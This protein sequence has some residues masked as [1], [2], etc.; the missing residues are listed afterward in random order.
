MVRKVHPP[1]EMPH[2]DWGAGSSGGT[3]VEYYMLLSFSIFANSES[4]T[5]AAILR[6]LSALEQRHSDRVLVHYPMPTKEDDYRRNLLAKIQ[7][8][9]S[10]RLQK[11]LAFVLICGKPFE[12]FHGDVHSFAIVNFDDYFGEEGNLNEIQL[13]KD[14]AELSELIRTKASVVSYVQEASAKKSSW[15]DALELKP[16]VWGIRFDLRK[17]A[18]L[19]KKT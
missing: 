9:F 18:K 2:G 1:L 14:L 17:Y 11:S 10:E 3:P 15:V 12:R 19:K 16:G 6:S 13:S 4:A 8:D 7:S 5:G